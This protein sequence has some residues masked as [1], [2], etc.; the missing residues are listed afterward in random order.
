MK[1]ATRFDNGLRYREP[2]DPAQVQLTPEYVLGPVRAALGGWIGLDPCTTPDNPCGA[3]RFYAPPE[4][5]LTL[6]WASVASRIYVNPPYG[7]AR[8]V[9]VSRC[10]EAGEAGAKVVALIPAATDTR[11]FQKAMS[12]AAAVVFI[13]GRVKFEVLRPNRRRAAA[14]HPSALIGWNAS[15]GPCAHLGL[16]AAAL[17]E[18]QGG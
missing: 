14:S 3:E 2:S 10:V 12:T 5:G 15:L 6:P 7:K 11:T 17:S 8:D 4:N 13:R 18:V 9:W 1:A 16:I